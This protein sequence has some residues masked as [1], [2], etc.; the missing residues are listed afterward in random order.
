[1]LFLQQYS[2]KEELL[3]NMM[4]LL[5]N[6]AEVQSLRVHL[7]QLPYM[8][9]F[10]DLI[11]TVRESIEVFY[12]YILINIFNI[13]IFIIFSVYFFVIRYHIMQLAY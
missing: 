5:G 1:M 7:M 10:T 13:Y 6:V 8:V 9:V 3:K 4:G 12:T 11:R 2:R